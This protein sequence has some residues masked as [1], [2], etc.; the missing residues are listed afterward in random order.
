MEHRGSGPGRSAP[1]VPVDDAPRV[2]GDRPCVTGSRWVLRPTPMPIAATGC[3]HRT[4]G[5]DHADDLLGHR[6]RQ[7]PAHLI[8]VRSATG[9]PARRKPSRGLRLPGAQ[10]AL[11]RSRAQGLPRTCSE[12]GSAAALARRP[13]SLRLSLGAPTRARPLAGTTSR[14]RGSRRLRTPPL[15]QPVETLSPGCVLVRGR[16]LRV[17]TFQPVETPSPG[18]Q[19]RASCAVGACAPHCWSSL[20]RPRPRAHP[21]ARA[22]APTGHEHAGRPGKGS[23]QARPAVGCAG[24]DRARARGCAR[25]RGLDRLDHRWGAKAPT[26]HEHAGSPG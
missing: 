26:A 6:C 5:A 4:A 2:R 21:R 12:G 15:V 17:P 16:R 3:A 22:Q 9:P 10:R 19:P 18:A 1:V 11:A 23:R 14:A 24:A 13:H 7:R 8:P 20:S 25:G